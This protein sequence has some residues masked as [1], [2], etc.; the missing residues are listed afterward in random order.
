MLKPARGAMGNGIVVVIG[1]RGDRFVR[2]GG[3]EI[4]REDFLY[5]AAGII[6]GLYSLAG[7][8]ATSAM[9]EERLEAHPALAAPLHRRR[10]RRAR[11]RLPRRAR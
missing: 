4:S 1:R 10:A 9:V 11:D 7:P 6:S 5:H 8:A 3:R 2:S